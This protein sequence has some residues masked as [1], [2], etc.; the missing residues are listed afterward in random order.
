MAININTVMIGGNL[1]RD[2]QVKFLANEQAVAN[3]GV[4]V[5]ETWKSKDG[6]KKES[7]TF[8]EIEVWGKTAELCG[9]YLTKGQPVLVEGKLTQST[10]EKDGQKITKTRVKGEK[11]HFLGRKPENATSGTQEAEK[12]LNRSGN[13]S[14][15]APAARPATYDDPNSPPF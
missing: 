2:V 9:Q 6:E 10:Y 13:A 7:T 1:T 8:V 3:F 12:S 15:E 11:V 14:S 5:N 4:A